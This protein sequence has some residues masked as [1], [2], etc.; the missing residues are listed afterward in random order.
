MGVSRAFAEAHDDGGIIGALND[1][2]SRKKSGHLLP[3]IYGGDGAKLY[4]RFIQGNDK[5]YLYDSEVSLWSNRSELIAK[6]ISDT[7][8]L[9]VIGP[10]PLSSFSQKEGRLIHLLPSL[11]QVHLVDVSEEFNCS[12]KKFINE[13]LLQSGQDVLVQSHCMNYLDFSADHLNG[14]TSVVSTGSIVSNL[15]DVVEHCFPDAATKD[16]LGAFHSFA[17]GEGHVVL[18]YDASSVGYKL[19]ESYDHPLFKVLIE[20]MFFTAIEDGLSGGQDYL[21][22]TKKSFE[23]QP[24]WDS[25]ARNMQHRM[26]AIRPL[27]LVLNGAYSGVENYF[28]ECGDCY[29]VGNSYKP[30][31]DRMSMLADL[32]GYRDSFALSNADGIVEHVF[33]I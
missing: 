29:V 23:Y 24:F 31:V 7:E 12:S 2:F 15:E 33:H 10:G 30:S 9:V 18:G 21:D 17:G 27:R 19:Y 13:V 25:R 20:H 22:R 6:E 32:V 14:I 1:L 16:C 26:V 4:D 28:V 5:Y 3:Y 11:K 8:N